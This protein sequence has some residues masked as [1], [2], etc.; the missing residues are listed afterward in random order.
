MIYRT[1]T[2]S[3]YKTMTFAINAWYR[4]FRLSANDQATTVLCMAA[5]ELFQHGRTRRDD[6]CA[7]LLERFPAAELLKQNAKTSISVH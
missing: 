3:D 6:L 2:Y 1:M 7:G 5:L 4:H